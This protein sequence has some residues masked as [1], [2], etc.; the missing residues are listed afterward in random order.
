MQSCQLSTAVVTLKSFISIGLIIRL[1][2]CRVL[3]LKCVYF[4]VI[5]SLY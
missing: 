1:K 3:K 2:I 5:S 4:A